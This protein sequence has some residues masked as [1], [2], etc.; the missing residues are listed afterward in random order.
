VIVE[1][2]IEFKQKVLQAAEDYSPSVIANYVY[3][4]SKNY[5]RFYA[6][7]SIFGEENP[8]KR[9]F[10]IALSAQ[11]AKVIKLALGLLG[12]EAPERM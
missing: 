1:Q 6:D 7:L 2:L 9:A 8:Q 5:S 11:T 4:L 3:D 12:I 10:R